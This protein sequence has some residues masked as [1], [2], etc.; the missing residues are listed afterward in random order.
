ME[1]NNNREKVLEALDALT[2]VGCYMLVAAI[3]NHAFGPKKTFVMKITVP[4]AII[5]GG[6]AL[7][8]VAKREIRDIG[9]YIYDKL[10]GA[11]EVEE[12]ASDEPEPTV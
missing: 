4:W 12:D 9:G 1:K 2:E 7:G 8:K 11:V 10:A 5:G 6:R 3:A